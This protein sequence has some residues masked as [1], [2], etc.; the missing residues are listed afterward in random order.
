MRVRGAH[1][2]SIAV[3]NLVALSDNGRVLTAVTTA[4][5]HHLVSTLGRTPDARVLEVWQHA[6]NV[7]TAAG[8]GAHPPLAVTLL[9][10]SIAA[11][12]EHA[13]RAPSAVRPAL[14]CAT[15]HGQRNTNRGGVLGSRPIPAGRSGRRWQWMPASSLG[16]QLATADGPAATLQPFAQL[17][18]AWRRQH[19]Y[20]PQVPA[21]RTLT[22]VLI[23]QCIN[24]LCHRPD[25]ASVVDDEAMVDVMEAA[26]SA[27]VARSD[28]VPLLRAG[29]THAD[30]TL[31]TPPPL[32]EVPAWPTATASTATWAAAA[33]RNFAA[34]SDVPAAP[35]T[36]ATAWTALWLAAAEHVVRLAA[37]VR[38]ASADGAIPAAPPAAAAAA[39][40]AAS[41]AAAA[42]V[43]DLCNDEW[44]SDAALRP[45]AALQLAAVAQ[46]PQL[47]DL[48]Q[49]DAPQLWR[50]LQHVPALLA[51][52]AAAAPPER[53]D[54]GWAAVLVRACH[55]RVIRRALLYVPALLLDDTAASAQTVAQALVEAPVATRSPATARSAM[56][57]A[58]EVLARPAGHAGRT[59][60]LRAL[61]VP[62]APAWAS[63][64]T[65][66]LGDAGAAG[67]AAGAAAGGGA[68]DDGGAGAIARRLVA[69]LQT[70][71]ESNGDAD[72][73][74]ARTVM[75]RVHLGLQGAL[76]HAIGRWPRTAFGA[77]LDAATTA[78]TDESAARAA[79]DA[80]WLPFLRSLPDKAATL[81]RTN[82]AAQSSTALDAEAFLESA[83][84]AVDAVM[85]LYLTP[86]D[87]AATY[88]AWTA[89]AWRPVGALP[90]PQAPLLPVKFAADLSQPGRLAFRPPPPAVLQRPV[91]WD[92]DVADQ[93]GGPDSEAGA[94][95][96]VGAAD[97]DAAL[98]VR[99]TVAVAC[100]EQGRECGRC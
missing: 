31:A 40:A 28:L 67:A 17:L 70:V 13:S 54:D 37:A 25:S 80:C 52:A 84:I 73:A 5:L 66:A 63:W 19:T 38:P 95:G 50:A 29:A 100:G 76:A 68:D 30:A 9:V 18:G 74:F 60:L 61:A 15:P 27:M 94:A 10:A 72:Q 69:S 32:A 56:R 26:R 59:L 55:E 71:C 45:S 96:S 78:W 36:V 11:V 47:R 82:R 62:A 92:W 39:A 24:R 41:A 58:V 3:D 14:P 43:L 57:V 6:V 89:A 48:S 49:A 7:A 20:V 12:A 85:A 79:I 21:P 88:E 51:A 8:P 98:P 23:Q 97:D 86:G 83:A 65:V 46:V 2:V 35:P 22:M 34:S 1:A 87:A 93:P 81:W 90:A 42:A 77:L 44:W 99:A 75:E 91:L 33:T 53:T 4:L 64:F 16:A